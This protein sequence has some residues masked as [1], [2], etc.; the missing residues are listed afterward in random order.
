MTHRS[1]YARIERAIRYLDEH[2]PEQ[3]SLA[4]VARVVGLSEFHFQRLFQRWAGVSPKSFLRYVTLSH[5]RRQ[6]RG[7]QSLLQASL[8]LGLSGA[9][10]LHDLFVRIEAMTPGEYRAQATG[11]SLRWG[12]HDTPFGPALLIATE[13]GLCGLSFEA[14]EGLDELQARWP[15][16]QFIQ[17]PRFTAPYAEVLRARTQGRPVAPLAVL[18]KGTPFQLKVWEAL[19]RIPEGQVLT[20][21]GLA[22]QV[23]ATRGARAV[24]SAVGDNPIAFLIPC[25]R[26]IR[27]TGALGGYRWGEARKRA[28]LALERARGG[29]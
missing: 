7:E 11:L 14:E 16:A 4:E 13:R 1:D 12:R 17:A 18:L 10:R 24:G 6:L 23:G 19:L 3:P 25:H 5:A 21:G 26:V 28:M 8:A 22:A 15:G 9:S 27:G 29:G 2:H 20:Y